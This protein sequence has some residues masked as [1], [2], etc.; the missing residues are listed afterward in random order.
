[1]SRWIRYE[2]LTSPLPPLTNCCYQV[3]TENDREDTTKIETGEAIGLVPTSA[4][5]SVQQINR[6]KILTSVCTAKN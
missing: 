4:L 5:F 2:N 1:M 6:I 3:L